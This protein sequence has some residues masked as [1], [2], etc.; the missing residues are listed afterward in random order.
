[1]LGTVKPRENDRE[2]GDVAGELQAQVCSDTAPART[3]L[4][5]IRWREKGLQ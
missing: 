4:S 2:D 1:V 3:R 5:G